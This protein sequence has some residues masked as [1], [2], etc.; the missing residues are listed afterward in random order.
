M[1]ADTKH[2]KNDNSL[3]Q[4]LKNGDVNTY[5]EIYDHYS[6]ELM[7]Y[8]ASRLTDYED[9]ADLVHD[10]FLKLWLSKTQIKDLRPYLYTLLRN[11]IIDHIR[12]NSTRTVYAKMLQSLVEPEYNME[13]ELNARELQK[14]V[15]EAISGMPARA[16][17]I[18]KMSRLENLSIQ[19]IAQRLNISEQTVKNQLSIAN[20]LLRQA[21]KGGLLLL[22]LQLWS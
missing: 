12:K 4:E 11:L 9:A 10:V 2:H 18:Y 13:E 22:I 21:S 15:D 20:N 6:K 16:K 7:A 1:P 19:Q 17:E 14:I 5:L 3:L 8:A